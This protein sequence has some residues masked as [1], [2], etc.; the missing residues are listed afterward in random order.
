VPDSEAQW[1]RPVQIYD[2]TPRDGLQLETIELPSSV[3]AEL[4]RR[5]A[6]AGVRRIE[7]VSFVSPKAVPQLADAEAVLDAVGDVAAELVG[8]VV[9]TRGVERAGQTSV[10]GINAVV[11]ASDT[12]S[13]R[14]QNVGTD[15]GIRIWSEIADCARQQGITP[16]V[17]IAAAFGCPFEGEIATSR[18][19]EIAARIAESGPAEICLADTIGVAVPTEV[20][21]RVAA[22]RSAVGPDV[23]LRLHLHDT[24]HTAVANVVAGLAAGIDI[25]DCSIG[26]LG[27]CPFAPGATGNVAMED[28]LYVFHRMGAETGIDLDQ[29]L[30][31]TRWFEDV[32]D[33]RLPGAIAHVSPFPI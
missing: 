26:G 3:K 10:S 13:R 21:P 5:S 18:V 20:A 1:L 19:G 28:V 7:A 4:I 33:R 31:T 29:I 16:T 15:D 23:P 8:L 2:V 6:A 14:N 11:V 9:N 25:F 12:F 17:T 24:R 30:S 22:V 32:L 27:G